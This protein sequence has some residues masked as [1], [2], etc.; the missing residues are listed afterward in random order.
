MIR[1]LLLALIGYGLYRWLKPRLGTSWQHGEEAENSR[2]AELIRDP[3]CG[4]Y[5]LRNKGVSAR[6]DG[7]TLF[8]CS[9]QCRDAYLEKQIKESERG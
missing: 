6:I 5:F 9:P 7:K 1:L 3:E 4:A 2:E 8:F